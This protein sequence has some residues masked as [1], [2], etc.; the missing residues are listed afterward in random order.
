MDGKPIDQDPMQMPSWS[1][2]MACVWIVNPSPKAAERLWN[3]SLE[4][5]LLDADDEENAEIQNARATLINVLTSGA[6]AASGLCADGTRAPIPALEWEDMTWGYDLRDSEGLVHLATSATGAVYTDI[7]LSRTDILKLWPEQK[8]RTADVLPFSNRRGPKT[9]VLE[10]V[11]A[12]MVSRSDMDDLRSMTEEVMAT[13]FDASRDTCRRA[14]NEV[15]SELV[16]QS[17]SDN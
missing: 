13:T 14:R 7:R 2:G 11:K 16:G 8:E 9:G 17:N 10:R 4:D 15:L 12:A 1:I 3:G 5:A 6:V